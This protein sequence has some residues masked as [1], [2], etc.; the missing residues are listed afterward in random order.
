ML[1]KLN[2]AKRQIYAIPIAHAAIPSSTL[3]PLWTAFEY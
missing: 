1:N 3:R 2:D